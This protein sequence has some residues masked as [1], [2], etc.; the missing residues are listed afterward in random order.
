[1]TALEYMAVIAPNLAAMPNASVFIDMARTELGVSYFGDQFEI[2]LAYLTAHKMTLLTD[3]ARSGGTAGGVSSKSEGSL[4]I[5]FSSIGAGSA[6]SLYQ[7][8]FGVEFVRIRN[9]CS[10]PGIAVTG[11]NDAWD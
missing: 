10:M 7:T 5:S 2:A 1:M 11:G 4:S 9:T 8:H 3:T 6:N